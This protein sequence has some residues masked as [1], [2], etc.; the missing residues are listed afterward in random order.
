M[1]EALIKGFANPQYQPIGGTLAKVV[2]YGKDVWFFWC[3]Q[4][5]YS[6]GTGRFLLVLVTIRRRTSRCGSSARTK[7]LLRLIRQ[8]RSAA[9][10]GL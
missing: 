10:F 5:L 2:S 6:R 9:Q 3:L 8:V 7:H 1:D 4:I